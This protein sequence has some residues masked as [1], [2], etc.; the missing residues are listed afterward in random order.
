[1]VTRAEPAAGSRFESST[2]Q[3][4]ANLEPANLEPGTRPQGAE[5]PPW[6]SVV[7]PVYNEEDNLPELYRR[8]RAVLEGVGRPWEIIFVDDGS[9][10]GSVALLRELASRDARVV[11]V[12]L[13]RN[14]G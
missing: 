8:L 6:L 14:F 4:A 13:V 9:R 12:E 3:A 1:M 7:I 5:G 10:D 2:F 11:V